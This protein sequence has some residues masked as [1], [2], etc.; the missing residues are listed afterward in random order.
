MKYVRQMDYDHVLY[1]VVPPRPDSDWDPDDYF[2][3]VDE[4]GC[5]LAAAIMMADRLL[6][7][8]NFDI[9][10][11][12]QLSY[13][14]KAN[15]AGTNYEIYGPALAKELG[16]KYVATNDAEQLV[17]CLRTGGAAVVNCS[18][19]REG[20]IGV[21]SHGGHFVTAVSVEEDGRIA[22]LDPSFREGK[23]DEEDR[24]R[25]VEVKGKL[26][27]ASPDVVAEDCCW[28][29]FHNFHLFWRK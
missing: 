20:H 2:G 29:T 4:A 6:V 24:K 23:Y 12:L 15:I 22:I 14:S 26:L 18:G 10:E 3:T 28:N 21:F 1:Y 27:L 9:K 19:D 16:L 13:D 5:G 8:P 25:K 7:E 17:H 11:A